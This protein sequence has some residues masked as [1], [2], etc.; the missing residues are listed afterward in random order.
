MKLSNEEFLFL[1][2]ELD[3][4]PLVEGEELEYT[5][6]AHPLLYYVAVGKEHESITLFVEDTKIFSLKNEILN[7]F[8]CEKFGESTDNLYMLHRLK[9]GVNG[10]AKRHRDRFSTYKTV[11]LVLSDDFEGGDMYMN[12]ERVELNKAG[13]YIIFNGGKDFHEIKPITKGVRDVLIIWFS[14]NQRKFSL[15]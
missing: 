12:D 8:I 15:I 1:K 10:F 13:E 2:K 9:Y 14:T 7:K 6:K 4:T 3:N 11:S 5:K